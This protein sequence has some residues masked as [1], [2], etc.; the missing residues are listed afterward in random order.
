MASQSPA[1]LILPQWKKGGKQTNNDPAKPDDEKK[2]ACVKI[3]ESTKWVDVGVWLI[4]M[5]QRLWFEISE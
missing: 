1:D 5:R 3:S 4:D 2:P